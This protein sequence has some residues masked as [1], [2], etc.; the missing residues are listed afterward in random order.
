VRITHPFHPLCGRS[1]ELV[2]RS[3]HWGEDRVIYRAP[4]GTFPSIAAAFT[5]VE[6]PDIFQ[7]I[8]AGRAAFRTADLVRLLAL[9]QQLAGRRDAEDM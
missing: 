7:R 1:F 4:D 5:D 6:P 8:S 9:F 3:P 2:S